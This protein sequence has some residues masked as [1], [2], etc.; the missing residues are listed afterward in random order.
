MR[1]D[2]SLILFNTQNLYVLGQN[3]RYSFY[4]F[5]F[6][7]VLMITAHQSKNLSANARYQLCKLLYYSMTEFKGSIEKWQRIKIN[8]QTVC[9]FIDDNNFMRIIN[10]C[11]CFAYAFKNYGNCLD[12]LELSSHPLELKF[13]DIRQTSRGK[14]TS[15]VAINNVSK[16]LIREEILC[17]LGIK[18]KGVRGRCNLAGSSNNEDWKI[19]IPNDIDMSMI[20][21]E[22]IQICN[23]DFSQEQFLNSNS[24]KLT[25]FLNTIT[26]TFIPKLYS[27]NSGAKIVNRNH[28][29]NKK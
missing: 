10:D 13:G 3:E 6:Y 5:Q 12:T 16:S 4:T 24:W 18:R 21:N 25:I 1:D 8:N 22:L 14:D 23:N 11:F 26:P 19:E 17:N 2:L 9:N 7:I 28:N 27:S 20:P 29:Y 15:D